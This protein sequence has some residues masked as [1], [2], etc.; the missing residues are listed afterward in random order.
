MTRRLSAILIV[1]ASV[2]VPEAA[3][4]QAAPAKLA[5]DIADVHPSPRGDWSKT[6]SH[7]MQG[8]TLAGDRYQLRRATMLDLIRTAYNVDADK[9]YGGPSWIDYDRFGVIAK[10]KP[11][12]RS[13]TL[14]L[15]LQALLADRFHLVLKTETQPVPGYLLKTGKGSLQ[16]KTPDDGTG[17]PGCQNSFPRDNGVSY[18][19]FQCRNMTMADFAAFLHRPGS[20]PVMDSTGLDG[21]WDIDFKYPSASVGAGFP[22]GGVMDALEKLGLKLE[23]GKVPQSVLTVESVDELPSANLSEVTKALPPLPDPQFEVASIRPCEE[24][25]SRSPQVQSGGRMTLTCIPPGILVSQAWNLAPFEQ[26]VGAPKWWGGSTAHN[27]TIVAKAPADASSD[28]DTLNA[29]LRALLI[30][31]YKM[32]VH[33]EDRPMDVDTLVAV[34]PKLTKANPANRTGCARENEI[35]PGQGAVIYLDCKNMTMAQFAEQIQAYKVDLF[36]P[37]VDGTGLDGAWDFMLTYETARF[38]NQMARGGGADAGPVGVAEDPSG[39]ILFADAIQQQLGLKLEVH[40]RPEPVLVID[41]ME[42]FPTEN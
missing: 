29:M 2:L 33:Y 5:F 10:T 30:E 36:Y 18:D 27:I 15:M 32:A 17:S 12:T 41:H 16:L 21:A 37:V 11:G 6:V 25:I 20:L 35:H 1:L 23:P 26:P 4:S 8:P 22:G 34:K 14:R 13:A 31:R 3:F 42:E 24:N 39:S 28:R 40:K 19:N 9:I 38:G 7:W